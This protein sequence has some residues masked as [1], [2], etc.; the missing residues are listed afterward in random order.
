MTLAVWTLIVGVVVI[1]IV[2]FALGVTR[3]NERL[4]DSH[5]REA[6]ETRDLARVAQ[7]E[8]DRQAAEAEERSAR[9]RREQLAGEQQRLAA[10]ASRATAQDL[11]SRADEIDPDV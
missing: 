9:A 11:R 5:R 1:V 7:L 3:R 6:G 8:A 4:R 10:S 2:G